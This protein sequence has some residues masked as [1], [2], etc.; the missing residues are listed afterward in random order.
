M[1]VQMSIKYDRYKNAVSYKVLPYSS[2]WSCSW[3]KP[4]TISLS[5]PK[6]PQSH[7][8]CRP[9]SRELHSGATV[10]RRKTETK[11]GFCAQELPRGSSC[12]LAAF[13]LFRSWGGTVPIPHFTVSLSHSASFAC[14][15]PF[16]A[17]IY[18]FASHYF[19]LF[20]FLPKMFLLRIFNE[21][22]FLPFIAKKLLL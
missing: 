8:G 3:H 20:F 18:L 6:V 1:I 17:L 4:K 15:L 2:R 22:P 19:A 7:S 12:R 10:A 9:H 5:K 16:L 21:F 13:L 11:T 14:A